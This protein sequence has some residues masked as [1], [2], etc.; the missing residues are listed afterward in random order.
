MSSINTYDLVEKYDWVD[1]LLYKKYYDYALS[2]DNV[3]D[4][5]G[6][7]LIDE[8][9][10]WV[11]VALEKMCNPSIPPLCPTASEWIEPKYNRKRS[12]SDISDYEEEID[13]IMSGFENLSPISK[14]KYELDSEWSVET[15][16]FSEDYESDTDTTAIWVS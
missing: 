8:P 13:R 3:D 1:K 11:D 7:G 4:F 10:A 5:I 16:W 15:N 14:C 9:S 2:I 6:L 12:E